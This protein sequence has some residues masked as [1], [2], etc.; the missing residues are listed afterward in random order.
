MQLQTLTHRLPPAYLTSGS[1]RSVLDRPSDLSRLAS[2]FV[3]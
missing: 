1:S 2:Y 3:A